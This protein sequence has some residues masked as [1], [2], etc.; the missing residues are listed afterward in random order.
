M[1]SELSVCQTEQD[2][3]ELERS[4]VELLMKK[5][6]TVSF[7]ESCTGGALSARIVNVPG[8]SD[9]FEEGYVTYSNAAK[10]KILGVSKKTLD[11][12]GAV[13][14]ECAKEMAEGCS[15]VSGAGF[16]LSVTGLAGPGGGT[17]ETPVGTV[18][19]GCC[20]GDQ[21]LVREYHFLGDRDTIRRSASTCALL[22]LKE[23]LMDGSSAS[24]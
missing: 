9:I 4:V 24:D 6:K 3:G 5:K 18:F 17:E 16:C 10:H 11:T 2:A 14:A 15:R 7:A 21:T 20:Y 1:S 12:V 22:L 19:I 8:A 23:C 13:S